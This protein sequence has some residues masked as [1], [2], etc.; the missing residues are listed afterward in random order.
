MKMHFDISDSYH[1]P[2]AAPQRGQSDGGLSDAEQV[3]KSTSMKVRGDLS[4]SS[5]KPR[6]N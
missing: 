1:P 5:T 6:Q 4:R 3:S 2:L